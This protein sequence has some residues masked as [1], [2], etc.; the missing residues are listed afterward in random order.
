MNGSFLLEEK[1]LQDLPK[2][3]LIAHIIPHI[4]QPLLD[5]I[6]HFKKRVAKL[7]QML[8]KDGTFVVCQHPGGCVAEIKGMYQCKKC[9]ARLCAT[10]RV[11]IPDAFL[12]PVWFYSSCLS[13]AKRAKK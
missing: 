12:N 7:T 10:H 9:S 1:M 2:D 3:V 11:V 13:C 8:E 5:E 4:Q 6:E